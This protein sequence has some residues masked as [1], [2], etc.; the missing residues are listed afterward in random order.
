MLP[1]VRSLKSGRKA[2]CSSEHAIFE[3]H[4]ASRWHGDGHRISVI[5]GI[6]LAVWSALESLQLPAN[7]LVYTQFYGRGHVRMVWIRS[8]LLDSHPPHGRIYYDF[9]FESDNLDTLC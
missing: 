5:R 3:H 8:T 7:V 6:R 1:D 2:A 4:R 9:S